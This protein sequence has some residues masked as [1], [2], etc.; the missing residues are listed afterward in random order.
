M[1]PEVHHRRLRSRGG[2]HDVRN[3][4]VL[5]GNCH[6]WCHA[7]PEKAGKVGLVVSAWGPEPHLVAIEPAGVKVFLR[8]NGEYSETPDA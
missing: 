6:R 1:G 5:H 2:T 7:N 3:L 4:V 8:S